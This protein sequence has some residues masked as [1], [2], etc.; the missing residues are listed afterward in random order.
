MAI[1]LSDNI[2]VS[3]PKPID[4]RYLNVTGGTY[5]SACVVCTS[6]PVGER[7]LGLTVLI[8]SG[9]CNIEY[10]FK[11]NVNT[12]IEK[13]YDTVVPFG[14]YITGAS[15]MGDYVQ[16]SSC[17]KLVLVGFGASPIDNC[18]FSENNNYF[19]DCSG[20]VRIGEYPHRGLVRRAYVNPTRN[21]SWIFNAGTGTW[22]LTNY[23][24]LTRV[25]CTIS[26]DYVSVYQ[27]TTWSGY[28]SSGGTSVSATGTL[29]SGCTVIYGAPVY[30]CV[31]NQDLHY[32]SVVS[33]T[34]N[35]LAVS[36][37][38]YYVRLSGTSAILSGENIGSGTGV[39]LRTPV[40]GT[41]LNFR[42]LRGS[43]DTTITTVGN[44][45]IIRAS[46]SGQTS[47]TGGTNIGFT[48]GTGVFAGNDNKT[49]QFRN[50]V[51]SGDT[52]VSL[53]DNTIVVHTVGG[54]VFAEDL[55][56]SIAAGK[57]FGK[58][59]NG[60]TIPA[61]GKTPAEV[62]KMA[63][64][65]ALEP[66]V[67]LSSSGNNVAFGESGKT[68]NLNFSYTIN[69][70]G[71][72]VD[73]VLLEWRRGGSGAWSALT[74][75]TGST[76]YNH[77]IDDSANRFNTAVL[78]YRYTVVDS[79]GA[80]GQTTHDVILQAYAAPSMSLS[81]NG[82]VTSPETQN[83]REK[84]NVDS[85][86]SG[87][88]TSQR[89]LVDITA[90]TLERRF[91]GGSWTVLASGSSLSTS[92]VTISSTPDMGVIPSS[93]I[94]IDYRITYVDEFTSGSG[95]A[96]AITFFYYSYYGYDPNITLTESQIEALENKSK[97][98]SQNLTWNSVTVPVGEYAYYAIPQA[99][100]YSNVTQILK[101]IPAPPETTA[102][103]NLSSVFV[104]NTYGEGL[105]YWIWK[106]NATNAYTGVGLIF[107]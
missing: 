30:S 11:D 99:V 61:S 45:I 20:Y 34:P 12:L 59:E 5:P 71:A 75:N 70:L 36:Y 26:C 60:D 58:Y 107:S 9:A 69:T 21:Y 78:N 79:A 10:W 52:S 85:S 17:Q 7:Y 97:L 39:V 35:L 73:N 102:W 1:N 48:G 91:N 50:I 43:G 28:I 95:G 2:K 68:V 88:I 31:E 13:K 51:G 47:I 63:I 8:N 44:E 74:T 19:V 4:S 40:T 80:T 72:T 22:I 96:Q 67:N 103:T 93:A 29:S 101:T 62:I 32:R 64:L 98:S 83:S 84:G 90:W 77:N 25:G 56:V 38:D 54:E 24:I 106:T 49:M 81:L 76:N 86:P 41:T 16:C 105:N 3:A 6:I 100:G 65:E 15:S 14:D 33:D 37:D 53:S 82:S 104:T 42:T 92:G 87:T 66:T 94:S 18:Y 89:S 46:I 57:T 23:D 55:Y 27:N